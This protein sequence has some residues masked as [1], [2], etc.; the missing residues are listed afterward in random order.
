MVK[1]LNAL[2]LLND[3]SRKYRQTLPSI[4]LFKLKINYENHNL[5]PCPLIMIVY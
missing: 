1:K 5:Y 2:A 3:T 4:V